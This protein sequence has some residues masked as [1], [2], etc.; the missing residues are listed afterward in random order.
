MKRLLALLLSCALLLPLAWGAPVEGV[1]PFVEAHCYECH[2]DGMD[3]GGLDF[4]VLGR[5]LTDPATSAT[6]EEIF[7][8]VQRREMPPSKATRQPSD[9]E[10]ARMAAVLGPAL[11]QG[12]CSGLKR[13]FV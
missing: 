11:A 5:D 8:R 13:W 4:D 12:N 1:V 9:E 7:D 3:K 2:G 10:R 6:W